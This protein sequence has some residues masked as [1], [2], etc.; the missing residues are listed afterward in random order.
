MVVGVGVVVVVV[1]EHVTL[2]DA[3]FV[4]SPLKPGAA[5]KN[6]RTAIPRS[7]GTE[8]STRAVSC[9][10]TSSRKWNCIMQYL[11]IDCELESVLCFRHP[12]ADSLNCF[13]CA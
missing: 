3:P 12:M 11:D 7:F 9:R 4:H 1:P 6:A 5:M 8:H 10:A 13:T 2:L